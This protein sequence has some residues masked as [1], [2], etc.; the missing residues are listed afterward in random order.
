MADVT[1]HCPYC[2][3]QCGMRLSGS[4]RGV[5]V[6][7][8]EEF[9]VNKGAMCR[10]GWTSAALL[11]DRERVTTPLVKENGTFRKA[12]WDE[13][14]DLIASRISAIQE[15]HGRDAV[16]VFGGGGL[17]NEKA[18]Q[19]GKFARVALRTS[20]IDYNG[21]WCMSSAATAG[22][23]AFGV[24]RG[25]PFPLADLA[26]PTSSSWSANLAE[27]MPPAARSSTASARGGKSS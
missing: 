8:W 13:A 9:P 11:N 27:T 12:G 1:T 6:G 4:R 10:K 17:T 24:D 25:L 16:A 15:A 18:Y 22:N 20:Q 26:G 7:A 14:L 23:R 2:S 21:R 3:L 5:E 19:L